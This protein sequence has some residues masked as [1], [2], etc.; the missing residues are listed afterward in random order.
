MFVKNYLIN[1]EK[2]EYKYDNNYNIIEVK[3]D[4]DVV[5]SYTYDA[6]NELI[7][8]VDYNNEYKITYSYDTNGNMLQKSRYDLNDNIIE[9]NTFVI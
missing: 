2:Y 5:N 6:L 1:E 4:G 8:E 3:K 7:C 9:T